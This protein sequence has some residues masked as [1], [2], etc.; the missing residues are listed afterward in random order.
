MTQIQQAPTAQSESA[1]ARL[2]A[3]YKGRQI[4][5]SKLQYLLFLLLAN[6]KR[7]SSHK[8]MQII[9][10]SDPRKEVQYLRRKGIDVQDEWIASTKKIPRHKRYWID[11]N[12][13]GKEVRNE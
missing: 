11:P 7:Y 3:H 5:L 6:G 8:I 2:I 4:S 12:E 10:T 1:G 9:H 13:C